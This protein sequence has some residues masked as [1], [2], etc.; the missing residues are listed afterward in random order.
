[1]PPPATR[2]QQR[3]L[4]LGGVDQRR[5]GDLNFFL[6]GPDDMAQDILRLAE[7][8]ATT[9]GTAVRKPFDRAIR[10]HRRHLLVPLWVHPVVY[11]PGSR[12]QASPTKS[13]FFCRWK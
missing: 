4:F 8:G 12:I 7:G 11:T 13:R 2:G 3:A 5:V 6:L 10:A 1:M 9:V